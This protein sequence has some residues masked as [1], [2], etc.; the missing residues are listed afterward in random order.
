MNG[1]VEQLNKF[2]PTKEMLWVSRNQMS[3]EGWGGSDLDTPV[4]EDW[5]NQSKFNGCNRQSMTCNKNGYV[6]ARLSGMKNKNGCVRVMVSLMK[7]DSL[8]VFRG[9]LYGC[10]L[11]ILTVIFSRACMTPQWS[12]Y[13]MTLFLR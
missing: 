7:Q 9:R 13:A 12:T 8:G 5:Y 10:D 4:N 11:S 2:Y 3:M 6:R 1:I